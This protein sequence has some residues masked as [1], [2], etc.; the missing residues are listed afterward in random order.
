MRSRRRPV[1]TVAVGVARSCDNPDCRVTYEPRHHRQVYHA[2]WCR[3][4]NANA[5]AAR[6]LE[7]AA[8]ARVA[9]R[10]VLLRRLRADFEEIV[11]DLRAEN[12]RLSRL[13]VEAQAEFDVERRLRVEA[14]RERESLRA[15]LARL[16][17][18]ARREGYEAGRASSSKDMRSPFR[19]IMT[20]TARPPEKNAPRRVVEHRPGE[21]ASAS[22]LAGNHFF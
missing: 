19:S 13:T 3:V 7:A 4:A 5:A 20:R 14:E 12:A 22:S 10:D 8:E 18:E 1:K 6:R 15:R 17:A 2:T 16:E 11:E 9:S 21:W